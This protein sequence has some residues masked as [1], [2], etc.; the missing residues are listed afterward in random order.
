MANKDAS[1]SAAGLVTPPKKGISNWIKFGVPVAIL[2]IVGAVL[3][4]VLGSRAANKNNNN[5][6]SGGSS[7]GASSGGNAPADPSAAASAEQAI[8]IYATATNSYYM[9]PLYPSTTNTAA[10]TTPTILD[11]T[12]PKFSWPKDSFAPTDASATTVRSDRPRLIAPAY[13]WNALPTLI[14]NDLYLKQWNDTIF[15]NATAYY[16]LPP[17]VYHM[18]GASGILDNAREI[19]ERIKAF[20]YAYRMT[21]DTKW[22]DRC[23]LELQ[24]AAGNGTTAFGP[25]ADRWNSGHFLDVAEFCSAFGIAYDWLYNVWT[26]DQKAQIRSTVNKYGLSLGVGAFNDATVAYGWWKD[27]VDGNWNCVCNA[28]LTLASLAILGDDTEGYANTLLGLTIPNAV[29][30]CA[31]GVSDDGTWAETPNYWYFGTTGH[32]EMASSLLTATGSDYGLLSSNPDFVKTGNFHMHVFGPTSLFD[33]GDHGPNKFSSTANSIIFYGSHYNEP[34]YMLFQREQRDA[35]EPWSMFW[36]DPASA[37]AFWDGK[38]LDGFFSNELDQWVGM[39]SSWTDIKALYVAMK[40]GLNQGH[41]THNDLDVGDFVLDALGTRWAGEFGSGDYLAPN[42]FSS[43]AQNSDRWKYYRKMTEGQNTILISQA[44]QLV[45]AKPVITKNGTTGTKQGSSTVVS[46]EDGSTAFWVADISSAYADATSV[47]RGVRM[48]NQRK[49]VL[50]QD[51]ITS[52][53]GIQWR[54]HTNATVTTNGASATLVRDGKTM[55]VSILSPSGATFS[56]SEAKRFDT[57]PTPPAP[58][59]ENPGITVLI[60]ALNAG[61]QNIQVL[62][63]PQWDDGTQ[64]KTPSG[65]ALDDWSLTSHN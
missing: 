52:T 38:E 22:S 13:K 44:N 29:Q 6:G 18:D 48:I 43:D 39:R 26:D 30:N 63:N 19:K 56:T 21:N 34:S 10:F 50:I 11:T 60:I 28:G 12:D 64:F 36:Y 46:L 32:A 17:V 16:N 23:W 58:D 14:Q 1:D 3:G 27:N 2:V 65:V 35:A 61:T 49:Q 25:D 57:D 54:M 24:N 45:T 62:F 15:G 4:G 20:A 5:G 40:A 33:W 51:E 7:S 55:E 42:Y 59:Q 37:G 9:V 41:Q 8:G 31:K 47:K 53:G